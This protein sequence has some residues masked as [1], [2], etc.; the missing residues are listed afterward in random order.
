MFLVLFFVYFLPLHPQDMRMHVLVVYLYYFYLCTLG[1]ALYVCLRGF[2][3][4]FYFLFLFAPQQ[5]VLTSR[6]TLRTPRHV[7]QTPSSLFRP[8]MTPMHTFQPSTT[9][10]HMFTGTPGPETHIQAI[11]R[12]FLLLFIFFWLRKRVYEQSYMRF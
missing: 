6:H 1:H 3:L 5:P 8:P 4:L 7:F 2:F 11:I 12:A 9:P 10:S